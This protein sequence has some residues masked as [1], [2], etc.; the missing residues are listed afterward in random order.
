MKLNAK[1]DPSASQ[2]VSASI[3][4]V[5][6]DLLNGFLIEETLHLAGHRVLGPAKTVPR[7]LAL[8]E[9]CQVDAA[10]LD[11]Q[12]QDQTSLLVARRLDD[13]GIPWAFT[14]GHSSAEIPAQF[15]HI[16]VLK[17]PFSINNLLELT[18]DALGRRRGFS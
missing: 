17:K 8:L 3:L 6:D 12:I 18:S 11:L 7:A 13:L 10:I 2:S 15:E 9:S 1:S 14:T 16:P 4:V 5:E